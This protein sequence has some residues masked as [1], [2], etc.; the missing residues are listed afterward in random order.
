MIIFSL[1]PFPRKQNPTHLA[2]C[3]GV[4]RN[5]NDNNQISSNLYSP[6]LPKCCPKVKYMQWC[7]AQLLLTPTPTSASS[8]IPAQICSL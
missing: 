1:M 2:Q 5:V 7:Q 4:A 8:H 3:Q 6:T